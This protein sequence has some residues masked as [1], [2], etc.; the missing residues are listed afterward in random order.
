M[1]L[2]PVTKRDKRKITSKKFGDVAMWASC[3]VIVIFP[4]MVILEQ[5]GSWIL[6]GYSVKLLLSFKSSLF[7]Y[8]N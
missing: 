8:K 6:G 5:S 7:F 2:G 4:F 3:D 1:K